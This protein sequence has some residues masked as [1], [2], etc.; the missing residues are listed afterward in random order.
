MTHRYTFQRI[1]DYFTGNVN[2]L[3]RQLLRRHIGACTKCQKELAV[4]QDLD[5]RLRRELT[6]YLQ[7][8]QQPSPEFMARI[9][10]QLAEMPPPQAKP[11]RSRMRTGL[12]FGLPAIVLAVTAAL[13][14][15]VLFNGGKTS[16]LTLATPVRGTITITQGE[17]L[18]TGTFEYVSSNSWRRYMDHLWVDGAPRWEE[19]YIDDRFYYRHAPS[20]WREHT[21]PLPDGF[22]AFPGLAA[23]TPGEGIL[24]AA[25]DLY[26]LAPS[27]KEVYEGETVTVHRGI[28]TTYTERLNARMG[29][30]GGLALELELRWERFR[31]Q[32]PEVEVLAD[33]SN[34]I[35]AIRVRVDLEEH[36]DPLLV[37][38]AI[39]EFNTQV[40]IASPESIE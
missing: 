21:G 35:K 5:A 10:R 27:H 17:V 25:V 12:A 23:F 9:H 28:D 13:V 31:Q 33:E 20:P 18:A 29:A 40:D 7:R 22:Q 2:W 37:E 38:I 4:Y 14:V 19:V 8:R 34:R 6:P 3:Q 26:E 1:P 32:P 39:T 36:D 30:R 11:K 16:A 24:D 15:G